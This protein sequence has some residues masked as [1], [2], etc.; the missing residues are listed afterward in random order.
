MTARAEPARGPALVITA[1]PFLDLTV[2]SWTSHDLDQ[3]HGPRT[4]PQYEPVARR[5]TLTIGFCP[6]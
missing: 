3:A 5:V 1:S 6:C 4:Q 2:R